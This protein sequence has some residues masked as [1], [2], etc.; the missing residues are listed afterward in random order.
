MD[1]DIFKIV[2]EF[3]QSVKDYFKD[4]NN[5]GVWLFLANLG[6]FSAPNDYL[7]WLA[8]IIIVI[9]V[10]VQL[11]RT[12]LWHLTGRNSF[13]TTLK[14]YNNKIDESD[15][16]FIYKK[17]LKKILIDLEK[18]YFTF[19]FSTL[20]IGYNFILSVIFLAASMVYMVLG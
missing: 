8:F 10:S 2:F 5:Q 11:A 20:K 13:K 6:A 16:E 1:N 17:Q 4:L 19:G 3:E 7:K 9:M 18:T 14:F 15:V 12:K